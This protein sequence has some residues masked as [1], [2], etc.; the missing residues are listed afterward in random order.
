MPRK[1]HTGRQKASI[2]KK[3]KREASKQWKG[4]QTAKKTHAR[5]EREAKKPVVDA[6]P[7]VQ[8]WV[9]EEFGKGYEKWW[10]RFEQAGVKEKKHLLDMA[11]AD[12]DE[13]VKPL[14]PRLAMRFVISRMRINARRKAAK[15]KVGAK[16]KRDKSKDSIAI[17]EKGVPNE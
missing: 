6:R 17:D 13:I 16:Q 9:D 12:L 5:R 7:F 1:I 14:K 11:P 15:E 4:R 3:F 8:K 10:K 2:L